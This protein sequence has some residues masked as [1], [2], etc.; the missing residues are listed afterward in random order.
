MNI[1]HTG[2]GVIII[3]Y[4][5]LECEQHFVEYFIWFQL[6][7]LIGFRSSNHGGQTTGTSNTWM[8]S[9]Q[10]KCSHNHCH[11]AS[12]TLGTMNAEDR[13]HWLVIWNC[14]NCKDYLLKMIM[15]GEITEQPANSS[16]VLYQLLWLFLIF[17]YLFPFRDQQDST[18]I[19]Q[20]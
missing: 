16:T 5:I 15:T 6:Q 8:I 3:V 14:S 19:V 1:V 2:I 9:C 20:T 13:F 4:P 12:S 7:K 11:I 10:D 17:P 18:Y